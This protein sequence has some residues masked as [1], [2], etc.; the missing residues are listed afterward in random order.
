MKKIIIVLTIFLIS[1]SPAKAETIRFKDVLAKTIKNSYDL[2]MSQTDIKISQTGIKEARAEYFPTLNLGYDIQNSRDLTNGTAAMTS[3]GT[4][5]IVN[6]TSYQSALS[7]GL[8]YNVFD[9]GSRGKKLDIAK[10]DKKVKQTVYIQNLRDLKTGLADTY[11]KVL[12]SNRELKTN[13]ELLALNKTLF[14]MKESLYNAGTIRKTDMADQAM[15][16]ATLINKIDDLR[17]A[18]KHSLSDLSFYTNENYTTSAKILTLSE[19]EEGVVPVHSV[20]KSPIKLEIN[21]L[22]IINIEKFPEYKK[23]QLEIEKKKDEL[24]VLKRQNLPQFKFYTNYYF[25]GTDASNFKNSF[26]DME[27]K[28]IT[29]WLASTLPVFDGFKNQAQREKAKLE[30]ERLTIERDKKVQKLL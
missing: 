27:S 26:N 24:T 9:F 1:L 25:Y 17:T 14:S 4:T 7:A 3:I 16:V 23:Y 6:S 12:L 30:I 15:K 8:Q 10:K 11:T 13:E 22:D 21:T 5:T 2:K 20:A 29:F 28:S 18:A 19:E